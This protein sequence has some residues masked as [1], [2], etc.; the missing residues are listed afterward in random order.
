MRG[1]R[2][3]NDLAETVCR[4]G[5]PDTISVPHMS[6]PR[7]REPTDVFLKHM[8]RMNSAI[9]LLMMLNQHYCLRD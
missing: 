6:F 8:L 5:N 3:G 4:A 2:D 9:T 1:G 7:R